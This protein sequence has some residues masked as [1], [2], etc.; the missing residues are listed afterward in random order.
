MGLFYL[1]L[2]KTSFDANT[3]EG[4]NYVREWYAKI[5]PQGQARSFR[6]LSVDDILC[7]VGHGE[8]TAPEFIEGKALGGKKFPANDVAAMVKKVVNPGH[9]HVLALMCEGAGRTKDG[10]VLKKSDLEITP[11]QN[12][13]SSCFIKLLA[14]ALGTGADGLTKIRV[15]GFATNIANPSFSALEFDAHK[16][17]KVYSKGGTVPLEPRWV[18]K[19]GDW[20]TFESSD[21]VK[22]G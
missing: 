15:G 14:R 20:C 16:L 5:G 10:V 19:D 21:R 18:N 4:D 2:F 1:E 13:K 11:A 9:V 3:T 17:P 7:L 12:G 22:Q 6:K 8:R